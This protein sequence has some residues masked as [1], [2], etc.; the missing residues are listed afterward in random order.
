MLRQKLIC[1]ALGATV[2]LVLQLAPAQALDTTWVA[3]SP[4]GDDNNACNPSTPCRFLPRAL[5]QVNPGGRIYV[6]DT[7]TY[8]GLGVVITKSVSII[9]RGVLASLAGSGVQTKIIVDA[10]PNDVVYLEGLEIAGIH[11]ANEPNGIVFKSG[12]QLH[13]RNCTIHGFNF[14]GIRIQA[15]GSSEVIISNCKIY[16]NKFGVWARKQGGSGPLE[17]L[18]DQVT[19][20]KNQTGVRA[21][22]AGTRVRINDSKIANNDTGLRSANNGRLISFGNNVIKA[23]G[24]DGAPTH[25]QSL[26]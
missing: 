13:I 10:G 26:E 11:G 2:A 22:R 20:S 7:G 12:A 18:L 4:L 6:Q 14:A 17:V 1:A 24:T 21:A 23:N 19:I 16:D 9:A 5:D 8:L 15:P 3:P 25:T